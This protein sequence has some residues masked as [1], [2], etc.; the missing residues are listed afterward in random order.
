[1]KLVKT[2]T[3]VEPRDLPRV[4]IKP[5][6]KP[7]CMKLLALFSLMT[8]VMMDEQQVSTV[9]EKPRT[10]HVPRMNIPKGYKSAVN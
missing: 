6:S 3:E 10:K 4:S 7:A 5:E 2:V 1:M 9:N 8:L